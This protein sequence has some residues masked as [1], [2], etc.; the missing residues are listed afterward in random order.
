MSEALPSD[1]LAV[2][3]HWPFCQSKCPYC[4]FNSHVRHQPIDSSAFAM[5]LV[6]ELLSF[7]ELTPG[8]MVTSVFF[9]GGT[10]S[11]MPPDAVAHVLNAI[12][13]QWDVSAEVEITLEANPTSAEAKNFRGYRAAGVNRLS[14]GIQA[15]NDTDLKMLGRLHS[16]EEA[17][18]AFDLATRIFRRTSFDLI[19]ARPNQ[20]LTDWRNE[21]LQAL[22]IQEGHLS[23]Y[24]LTIEEGTPFYVLHRSGALT[25][26]SE[27]TAVDLFEITQELTEAFGLEAYEVSNHAKPGHESRHNLAYWRY[28][29]F[30]GVGPG[31][32]SRLVLQGG[33]RLAASGERHPE[34]W[35]R[36]VASK[37]HGR[38]EEAHLTSVDQAIEMLLMGLRLKEGISKERFSLLWGGPLD[39]RKLSEFAAQGLVL[40]D[41]ADGRLR[42]TP[43]GTRVLNSL[44]AALASPN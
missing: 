2:Y 25:L 23:L 37:G 33:A 8:K 26:P 16:A 7:A 1:A 41:E 24:Q 30:V 4:D 18:A 19:Y 43:K 20:T 10:P 32:H 36:L 12:S 27:E 42:A 3:V 21:L 14:L 13:K 35:L 39:E 40:H 34:T 11:L 44:T 9:G 5:A 28:G 17:L 38:I 22:K 31:A 6:R 15:L 29:D